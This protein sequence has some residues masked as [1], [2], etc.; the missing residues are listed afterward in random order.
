VNIYKKV[1]PYTI[2]S[3]ARVNATIN[4]VKHV[5]KN[6]IEG[7]FIECGV[8]KGGQIMA[9]ILALNELKEERDIYLYDTFSGMPAPEKW[10]VKNKSGSRALD[11]F[12]KLK[13][14]ETSSNWCRSTINDVRKNVYSIPYNKSKIH[15]VKGMVEDTLPKN[16]HDKI[17]LLRLDTDWYS[18]TKIELE[19]L[20]PKLLKGGYLIIDDYGHWSGAKKAVDE[21][22][23]N[24]KLMITLC[25]DDGT[26]RSAIK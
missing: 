3:Q 1:K 15:F 5:I 14:S 4:A 7:D 2:C 21:Y 19:L 12:N 26:G 16:E 25:E 10:E 9:M 13:I 17:S 6:N 8:Y 22:I 11:K 18:S 24:N 20:F 23:T